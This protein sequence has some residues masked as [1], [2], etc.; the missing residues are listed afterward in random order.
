VIRGSLAR[1]YARALMEI[2]QEQGNYQQLGRELSELKELVDSDPSLKLVFSAPIVG[3]DQREKIVEGL[4]S[5]AGFSQVMVHF[6][7]LL[8]QKGRLPYIGPIAEAFRDLSDE[9]E[10]KVRASVTVAAPVPP[11]GEERIQAALMKL[12]GKQVIMDLAV[13]PELIG[14]VVA[15]VA[16]KLLDG[17]VR[18]QLR[19]MEEKLKSSA[20]L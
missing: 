11:A 8:N 17:S 3:K 7:K 6:L 15:R 10:G 5:R 18:T 19:A 16:G 4:A 13:D 12:T 14:G 1:R 9:A 2:G 20:A